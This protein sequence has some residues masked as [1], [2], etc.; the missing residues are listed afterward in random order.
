MSSRLPPYCSVI[1]HRGKDRSEF[2]CQTF[3]VQGQ[4]RISLCC[5]GG[6]RIEGEDF[7]D[8]LQR[9]CKKE[10]DWVPKNPTKQVEFYV[11]NIQ[12]AWFY[13]AD[14]PE[15]IKN[16]KF[17][18]EERGYGGI[19]GVWCSAEDPRLADYHKYVLEAWKK[20]EKNA[21][22]RRIC[23]LMQDEWT[24]PDWREVLIGPLSN[25]GMPYLVNLFIELLYFQ[26]IEYS[27]ESWDWSESAEKFCLAKDWKLLKYW[28][29]RSFGAKSGL[30]SSYPWFI[31]ERTAKAELRVEEPSTLE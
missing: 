26:A 11:N 18:G 19:G 24:K 8:C 4:N 2:F 5:F 10:M 16:L 28:K 20:G 15:S 25:L 27:E 7:L 14:G 30:T 23:L 9:C 1:L 3:Q 29:Y 13:E 21:Y 22:M 17:D 31:H 6:K 12:L